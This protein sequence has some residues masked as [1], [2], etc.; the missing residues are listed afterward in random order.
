[1]KFQI[2]PEETYNLLTV[3]IEKLD[4]AV[5]PELKSQIVVATNTGEDTDLIMDLTKVSFADSSGL[6]AILL[7]FRICRDA[8]NHL[9]IFGVQNRIMKLLE[10]SRL[11]ESLTIVNTLDEAIVVLDE[12]QS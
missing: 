6:S 7:A 12:V 11:T 3:N 4:S 9:V 10:I 2:Q 8:G 1:M 5:A